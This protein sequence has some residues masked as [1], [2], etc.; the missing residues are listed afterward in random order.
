MVVVH[1]LKEMRAMNRVLASILASTWLAAAAGC[2]ISNPSPYAHGLLQPAYNKAWN[3]AIDAMK[4]EGV[5]VALADLAGGR[6]EGRRGGV[7]VIGKVV[8]QSV[9]NVRVTFAAEDPDLAD[10]LQRRYEA[11]MAR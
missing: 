2:V 7:T 4:D 6:L 5:E 10:R 3:N 9:G 8:T 11:R 1:G